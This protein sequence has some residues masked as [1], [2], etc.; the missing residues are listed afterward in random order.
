M[1]FKKKNLDIV[2]LKYNFKMITIN[3]IL[4]R[5]KVMKNHS[6]SMSSLIINI[7]LPCFY[8][9]LAGQFVEIYPKAALIAFYFPFPLAINTIYFAYIIVLIPIDNAD[10]G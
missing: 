9:K 6:K 2:H 7:V 4:V 8:K 3:K 5:F 1:D 10:V